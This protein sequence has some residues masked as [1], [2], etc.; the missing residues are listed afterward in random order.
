M[1]LLQ[2]SRYFLDRYFRLKHYLRLLL[3]SSFKRRQLLIPQY[4]EVL[5]ATKMS[6]VPNHA[7]DSEA[8]EQAD[9]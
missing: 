1:R 9:E 5:S 3:L 4:C 2:V 7:Y 8:G 6:D